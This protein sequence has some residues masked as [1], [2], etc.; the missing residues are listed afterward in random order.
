MCY[1]EVGDYTICYIH[2]VLD[3]IRFLVAVSF[4]LRQI[5]AILKGNRAR[6]TNQP[7]T[8]P[9]TWQIPIWNS[10]HKHSECGNSPIT[11]TPGRPP[12]RKEAI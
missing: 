5:P 8:T 4:V 10:P 7:P 1:N 12:G 2:P 11:P 6:Q 9:F 3:S